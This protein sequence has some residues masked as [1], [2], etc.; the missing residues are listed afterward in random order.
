MNDLSGQPRALAS[1]LP[2]YWPRRLLHISSLR[3][4]EKNRENCYN[5]IREPRYATISYTWGRF[6][7]P[8]EETL[9]IAGIT[10]K[11]PSVDRE[12]FTV[13]HFARTIR[14]IGTISNV[15]F[16]WLDVACVNMTSGSDLD[17]EEISKQGDIFRGASQSFIWLSETTSEMLS[18]TLER[19]AAFV[20]TYRH[21]NHAL[22]GNHCHPQSS[23]QISPILGRLLADPWFKSLW[24]LQ[25]AMANPN[26]ILLSA[27]GSPT[28]L[29]AG[30]S[31]TGDR[32]S[33]IRLKERDISAP[34]WVL[35]SHEL[36]PIKGDETSTSRTAYVS[37]HSLAC[38]AQS[39]RDLAN[40]LP[41]RRV[42]A[43]IDAIRRT[44]QES[45]LP[46]LATYN[47]LHLWKVAQTR[48]AK[49]ANDRLEYFHRHVLGFP[50]VCSTSGTA[51]GSI[52]LDPYALFNSCFL[53]HF[54]VLS[55]LFTRK[56]PTRTP[57]SWYFDSDCDFPELDLLFTCFQEYSPMVITRE[58][59]N[60]ENPRVAF[61]G[62]ILPFG[63]VLDILLDRSSES[64]KLLGISFD[65][66]HIESAGR[67]SYIPAMSAL[68]TRQFDIG[69]QGQTWSISSQDA[70]HYTAAF[71]TAVSG[72][73][74][75][76][77]LL[78]LARAPGHTR[79]SSNLTIAAIVVPKQ[80]NNEW[81]RL[82]W[83]VWIYGD[84]AR[85]DLEIIP[86]GMIIGPQN[87]DAKTIDGIFA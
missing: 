31:T 66:S 19:T 74:Q 15:E 40:S 49:S 78:L 76:I 53:Y 41:Y 30:C 33:Q 79:S 61:T 47:L 63:K 50:R 48:N 4:Y 17:A 65:C 80:N 87:T 38:T 69:F 75:Q 27:D 13:G 7:V 32:E 2:F 73:E 12:H 29:P 60:A 54:P 85:D 82:G 23:S 20:D 70:L 67:K 42:T 83:C 52:S 59:H 25:E 57:N 18:T 9:K 28:I 36:L 16:L 44:I 39:I 22:E 14:A 68:P 84:R 37:L 51:K 64:S 71:Q 11:I 62:Q 26:A 72:L 81:Q 1:K 3:V 21:E 10:W 86:T 46:S 6:E 8:Q 43:P 34:S 58:V 55:Q 5:G 77:Q 24:T 45:G 56:K 35:H